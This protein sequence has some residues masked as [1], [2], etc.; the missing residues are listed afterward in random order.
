MVDI[1]PHTV[2]N[3]HIQDA[4]PWMKTVERSFNRS[5]TLDLATFDFATTPALFD[6]TGEY[7]R[8]GIPL[9]P[10]AGATGLW[11]PA[12]GTD[13]WEGLLFGVIRKAPG[14]TRSSAALMRHGV[15]FTPGLPVA[16]PSGTAPTTII[17]DAV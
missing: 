5:I 16:L 6:A 3:E 15:I 1:Q 11:V 10:Q 14:A 9:R 12:T 2:L 13:A 8:S 4:K 17:R 7:I